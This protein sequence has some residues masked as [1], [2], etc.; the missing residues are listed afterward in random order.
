M[1]QGGITKTS[2]KICEKE[3]TDRTTPTDFVDD[4]EVPKISDPITYSRSTDKQDK[5]SQIL[6][7]MALLGYRILTLGP[8]GPTFV[9]E[10]F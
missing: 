2:S 9:K 7:W 3:E 8:L 10:L 6:A 1:A 4:W 5:T